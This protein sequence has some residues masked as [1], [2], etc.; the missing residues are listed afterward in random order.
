MKHRQLTNLIFAGLIAIGSFLPGAAHS[1]TLSE[2]DLSLFNFDVTSYSQTNGGLNGAATASG[3]SNGIGWTISPTNLWSGR[4]TTNGSFSFGVLPKKT[5]NL[6]ASLAFTITFDQTIDKLLVAL[7]NDGTGT[8][9]I[10]FGI[11][12]TEWTSGVNFGSGNQAT[13]VSGSSALA[14]F[15]N[16]NSFTISNVNTNGITDGFDL[17]FHAIPKSA[18]PIPAAVWM[19]GTGLLGCVTYIK[20]RNL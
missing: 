9:S 5:D 4:T 8:D 10:N 7:S 19:L 3:T 6:H 14:L 11:A 2:F 20:R 17:A 18:V 12:P 15:E 1:S 13:L 16:I